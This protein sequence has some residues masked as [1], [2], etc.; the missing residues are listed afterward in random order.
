MNA[1]PP[2][3]RQTDRPQARPRKAA[4]RRRVTL[5]ERTGGWTGVATCLGIIV[6]ATLTTTL[7]G[8]RLNEISAMV[9]DAMQRAAP[10]AYD[11]Q[12]PVRIVAIDGES[13]ARYGQ[14]PWPRTYVAEMVTRLQQLGV[15]SISFDVLFAEPD[16]TSPE[17]IAES[18]R[19]FEPGAPVAPRMVQDTQHDIL[20]AR[21]IAQAP[22]ALGAVQVARSETARPFEQKFGLVMAGSDPR[23]ALTRNLAVEGPLPLLVENASGY[24]LAG[25]GVGDG[26]VVRR[27][28]LFATV[29]G[30]I[31]PALSME[32]LRVAQQARGYI[33]RSSDSS[34]EAGGGADPVVVEARNGGVD[35]PLGPD[36]A[37]W[38]HYAGRQPARIVPAW[39]LLEGPSVDPELGALLT[40]QIVLVGATAPGLRYLVDTPLETAVDAVTVHA[41]V[42][43]QILSGV[44]LQRPDW[45][46]GV[47]VLAIVTASLLVFV[48]TARGSALVG[49]SVTALILA[50]LFYGAWVA[51]RDMQLILS[52]V[53]PSL[54][55]A[56]NYVA[57][58]ALAYVR[59]R[60]E[61]GAVKNQFARFVAPE[62]IAEL[63]E[64]PANALRAGGSARDLTVLFCDARG[65]TTLSETMPPDE[66]INYLNTFLA[67][68]SD[69]VLKTGGT[70]DKYIGDCVMAFWNA[71]LYMDD[72]VD[73]ALDATFAIHAAEERL[74]A[75]FTADGQPAVAFG[76]GLNTG[77]ANVGL[78]GSPTRMEY[79]CVG[80]TV[81]VSARL[82]DLTKAYGV[83]N[84][85][86]A[87][88]E[89][90]ATRF[91]FLALDDAPI[92]G[93]KAAEKIYTA[94]RPRT[95]APENDIA[96]LQEAL[97]AAR[98]A[99]AGLEFDAAMA[100]LRAC[101]LPELDVAKLADALQK[102]RD[103][104]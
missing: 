26:R 50:A 74:N 76:V 12:L 63:S 96:S 5:R 41:E 45:A 28:Q 57:L 33:L 71:P 8:P 23:A 36:G 99:P 97:D 53:Q 62:I 66:L 20:L 64:D 78:M 101:A 93:R 15:A 84:V 39:R 2:P 75:R 37:I 91:A 80:D 27:A 34:A 95:G 98:L 100:R 103:L 3:P 54:A 42:L 72:H 88:V 7:Q 43:E 24:G 58:T 70:I 18:T 67:E 25:V 10:R 59:S 104:G 68:L 40:G 79:S 102:R 14:W 92:R 60:R 17:L 87:A 32:A 22:V 90:R 69:E 86:G 61:S 94:V 65:F 89:A 46:V 55:V 83:W 29:G 52:P 13:L 81:N 77:P 56:G 16:R 82:Q 19:R 9:A 35:I 6:L 21:A 11:P 38:V 30:Q 51:F 47:E 48:T 49:A 31:A 73:R 4:P 1:L 85:V 44:S